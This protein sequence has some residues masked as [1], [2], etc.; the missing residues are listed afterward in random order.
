LNAPR[1][2]LRKQAKRVAASPDAP[3]PS[4]CASVCRMHID[5]GLCEGC[6][7][8]LDEIAAWG[9]MEEGERRLV[10]AQIARRIE[11]HPE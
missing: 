10:W 9:R 2:Y 5:H 7:R 8:S 3:V 4:P 6:L 1:D 11:E